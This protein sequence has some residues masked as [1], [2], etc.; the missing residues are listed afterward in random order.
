MGGYGSGRRAERWLMTD[1]AR[2]RVFK[3]AR[4]ELDAW[5]EDFLPEHLLSRAARVQYEVMEGDHARQRW[6]RMRTMLTDGTFC[7]QNTRILAIRPR[8]GGLRWWFECGMPGVRDGRKV[9]GSAVCQRRVATLYFRDRRWAC[10]VCH[11][12][13]YGSR[14]KGAEKRRW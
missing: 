1:C 2:L 9:R 14:R 10:R 5:S 11:R 6:V 7:N 3:V 12:L 8:Y 13:E 4:L